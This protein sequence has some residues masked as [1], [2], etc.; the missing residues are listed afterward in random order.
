MQRKGLFC[1]AAEALSM[2]VGPRYSVRGKKD[3]FTQWLQQRAEHGLNYN[4]SKIASFGYCLG[5]VVG[6]ASSQG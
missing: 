4:R 6:E 2:Y 1:R 5:E 3:G